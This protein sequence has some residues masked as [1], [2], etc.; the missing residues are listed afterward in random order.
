MDG[1]LTNRSDIGAFEIHSKD[2][3]CSGVEAVRL[4]CSEYGSCGV[5]SIN[6]SKEDTCEENW[7]TQKIGN[8]IGK[9]DDAEGNECG[10]EE[11]VCVQIRMF[12]GEV[13]ETEKRWRRQTR[14]KRK[15]G[16]VKRVC[17]FSLP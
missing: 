10:A 13:K 11:H 16:R 6:G 8:R 12:E 14:T 3:V 17:V 4:Y 2:R 9:M 1:F 15:G 5:E 7:R